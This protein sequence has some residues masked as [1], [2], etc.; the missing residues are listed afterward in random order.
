MSG[1]RGL[2]RWLVSEETGESFRHC[3]Q[4]HLPLLETA[5]PWLVNKEFRRGEC[6]QEYAICQECRDEVTGRFSEESKEAVRLFLETEIDWAAR[7]R[8]FM[9]DEDSRFAACVAC[10]KPRDEAE[11][12]GISALFDEGGKPVTGPLPL[13][14][15][16]SCINRI[17][18]ALSVETR[19]AWKKFLEDHFPGPPSGEDQ[20]GE[21]F[22]GFL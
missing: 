2:E 9:M 8:D 14:V 21:G 17:S 1:M 12:F 7:V 4:C 16:G 13:L 18:A 15:C 20:G 5:G 19:A 3:I 22:S 10:R 11:G 6:I